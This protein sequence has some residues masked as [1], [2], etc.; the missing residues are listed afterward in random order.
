M[1]RLDIEVFEFLDVASRN[2]EFNALTSDVRNVSSRA[3]AGAWRSRSN[4]AVH[5][6]ASAELSSALPTA[7]QRRA[8]GTSDVGAL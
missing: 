6:I 1:R 8:F 7:S 5:G 2:I 3:P 4:I